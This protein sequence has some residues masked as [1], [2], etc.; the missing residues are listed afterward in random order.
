MSSV[1]WLLNR[2][3]FL[4]PHSTVV[5]AIRYNV[6]LL[7]ASDLPVTSRPI[8]SMSLGHIVSRYFFSKISNNG[9]RYS[10]KR[11]GETADPWGIPVWMMLISSVWPSEDIAAFL[12]L[13]KVSTH[14][15]SWRGNSF[16]VR[17][18]SRCLRYKL[19]N[20]PLTSM[21]REDAV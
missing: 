15:L 19:S 1:S 17:V 4:A 18:L 14:L 10:R 8:S 6:L 16:S 7:D 9:D 20:A 2:R 5:L 21:F 13:W 12:L 11:I 3:V